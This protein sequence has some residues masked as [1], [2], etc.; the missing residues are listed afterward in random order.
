ML[1]RSYL[2]ERLLGQSY[3]NKYFFQ[4][5]LANKS[6]LNFYYL[7]VQCPLCRLAATNGIMLRVRQICIYLDIKP[8]GSVVIRSLQSHQRLRRSG[9]CSFSI[10]NKFY[11]I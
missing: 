7:D 11:I 8:V 9:L 6:E 4:S 1:T 5:R 3:V 10:N 2:L